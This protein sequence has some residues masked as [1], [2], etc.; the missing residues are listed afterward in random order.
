MSST[1][2]SLL[3]WKTVES[4]RFTLLSAQGPFEL[5]QYE[6]MCCAIINIQGKCEEALTEGLLHLGE[7]LDGNNFKVSKIISSGTFF[8]IYKVNSWD[9]GL[10]LPANLDLHTTPKP[11]NRRVRIESLDP[12]RVGV[13]KFKGKASLEVLQ[14]REEELK[15]WILHKGL[16]YTG[17]LKVS[18]LDLGL[19]LSFMRTNEIHIDIL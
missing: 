6:R 19:P 1:I 14:R 16:S 18:H 15:K 9:I 7:Y 8:Q 12:V 5:R 3:N 13:L 2:L 11:I 4:S 17:P 10:I